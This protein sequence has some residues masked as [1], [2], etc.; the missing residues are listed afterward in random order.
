MGWPFPATAMLN[1]WTMMKGE[2]HLQTASLC[3]AT[4]N[5]LATGEWL[6][7]GTDLGM[8]VDRTVNDARDF[9]EWMAFLRYSPP[10]HTLPH[11]HTGTLKLTSAPRGTMRPPASSN[12]RLGHP[13]RGWMATLGVVS[14][15]SHPWQGNS[16]HSNRKRRNGRGNSGRWPF[17]TV[18]S[19]IGTLLVIS[20]LLTCKSPAC[21][22]TSWDAGY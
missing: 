9:M 16:T 17:L 22:P 18:P 2:Q 15:R 4:L 21:A 12:S 6:E 19:P 20:G 3:G 11:I 7:C 13:L 14:V 8:S 1:P 5:F 10:S